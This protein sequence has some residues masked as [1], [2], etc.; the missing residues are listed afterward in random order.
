MHLDNDFYSV[1]IQSIRDLLYA[2]ILSPED[3]P[4]CSGEV[5]T[6]P[7]TNHLLSILLLYF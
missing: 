3:K 4:F 5:L 6:A 2:N 7:F 1:N